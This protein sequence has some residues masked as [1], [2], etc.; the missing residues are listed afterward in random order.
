MQVGLAKRDPNILSLRLRITGW[1]NALLLSHPTKLTCPPPDRQKATFFDFRLP[2]TVSRFKNNYSTVRLGSKPTIRIMKNVQFI[3]SN[4]PALFCMFHPQKITVFSR[5]LAYFDIKIVHGLNKWVCGED[6]RSA[7]I[8][9]CN[10]NGISV[11]ND[12]IEKKLDLL[13]K[14]RGRKVANPDHW[15]A[16]LPQLTW[17]KVNWGSPAFFGSFF[18]CCSPGTA[19]QGCIVS[20]N[21]RAGHFH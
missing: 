1:R 2:P 9:Y 16:G 7:S 6:S 3:T 21:E 11:Y 5:I 8:F 17:V 14:G 20:G 18:R 12:I 19:K 13:K 15:K 10:L 4:S